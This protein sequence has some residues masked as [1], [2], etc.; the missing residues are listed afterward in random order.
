[1]FLN[2]WV[3]VLKCYL[4]LKGNLTGE[5]SHRLANDGGISPGPH[6]QKAF[7]DKL[8]FLK[9]SNLTMSHVTPDFITAIQQ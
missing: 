2:P 1:M 4:S 7:T 5:F 8:M 3:L 9:A 6:D